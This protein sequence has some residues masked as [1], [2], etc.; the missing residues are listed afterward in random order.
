[1]AKFHLSIFSF[2]T[3][4]ISR[5]PRQELNAVAC[6]IL[7]VVLAET[8]AR[9]LGNQGVLDGWNYWGNSVAEKYL[10]YEALAEQ[11]SLPPV[12]VA[13]DSTV[14]Y[15]VSPPDFDR[16]L[17]QNKSAFNFGILGN[18]PPAFDQ[19]FTD[20]V[21]RNATHNP[22]KL[23]VMFARG[24]FVTTSGHR[25][26]EAAITESPILRTARGEF[27]PANYIYLMRLWKSRSRVRDWLLGREVAKLEN[28]Q[29]GFRRQGNHGARIPSM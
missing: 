29:A 27:V 25:R 19:S 23:V 12:I 16:Q 13:G 6:A 8:G 28:S 11:G 15:G 4:R 21:L 2:D 5:W 17:G 20:L 14:A 3:L 22:E 7:I 18:F 26:T 9:H 24:A 10:S 1:M